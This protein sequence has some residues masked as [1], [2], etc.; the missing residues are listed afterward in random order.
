MPAASRIGDTHTCSIHVGGKIITG[1]PTVLIG[2]KLAA[3]VTDVAECEGP[4][5]DMIEG[6]SRTV[7]IG[8]QRA[9]R[10][11]DRTNGGHLTSGEPTVQ[12]GP[13][14]SPFDVKRAARRRRKQKYGRS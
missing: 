10:V 14:V 9:A 3:R 4:E 13:G 6:G 1:C 2:E 8:C 11:L 12:I 5:H 7:F